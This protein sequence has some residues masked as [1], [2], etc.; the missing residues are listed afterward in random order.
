L[1]EDRRHI[2]RQAGRRILGHLE[3]P[4]SFPSAGRN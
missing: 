3:K 1:R 2:G 4:V